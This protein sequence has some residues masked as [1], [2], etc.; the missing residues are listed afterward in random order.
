MTAHPYYPLGLHLP[1]YVP[2]GVDYVYI[3]GIFAVA[4]LVVIGVTWI[5]SGRRKGITT[6]DRMIACW[7]AVSGTIHLVVEGYVVVKAEFFTDETGNLR[8]YLSDVCT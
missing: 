6:T 8:N 2:M 4:T 3:L 5:I 1:N 7:F